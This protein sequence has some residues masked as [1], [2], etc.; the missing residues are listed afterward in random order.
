MEDFAYF[1][2]NSAQD[3]EGENNHATVVLM[4]VSHLRARTR[5]FLL[6]IFKYKTN[7]N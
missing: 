6:K 3:S 7:G 5:L 2:P 4:E 1:R